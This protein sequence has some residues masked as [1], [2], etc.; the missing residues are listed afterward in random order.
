MTRT[1]GSSRRKRAKSKLL[2]TA[3]GEK[4]V[5]ETDQL[6]KE[7]EQANA[8]IADPADRERVVPS[9]PCEGAGT[10]HHD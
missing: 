7:V 4:A 6:I 10:N 2:E 5:I 3:R 9:R 1:K 8:H